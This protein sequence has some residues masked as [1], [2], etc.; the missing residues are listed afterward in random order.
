[1]FKYNNRINNWVKKISIKEFQFKFLS[2]IIIMSAT[3]TEI[4]SLD[5]NKKKLDKCES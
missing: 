4:M 1:M 3:G 2:N 5:E